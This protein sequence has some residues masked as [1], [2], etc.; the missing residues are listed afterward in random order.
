[1]FKENKHIF[2]R[3]GLLYYSDFNEEFK[4]NTNASDFQLGAVISQNSK[5]IAFY[6]GKLT[7]AQI[8]YT[9]T[10]KEMLCIVEK[11]K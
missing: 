7:G 8:K 9:V 10:E 6:C 5:L 11:L 4:I 1:M 3:E 2:D